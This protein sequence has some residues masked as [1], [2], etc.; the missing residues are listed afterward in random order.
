M[1]MEFRILVTFG[2]IMIEDDWKR[3]EGIFPGADNALDLDLYGILGGL[4]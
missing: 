4:K 2:V 3:T 1:V